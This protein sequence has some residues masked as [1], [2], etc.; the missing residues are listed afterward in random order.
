VP[1]GKD[2]VVI[3]SAVMIVILSCFVAVCAVGTEES[4]AFTVNV[5]VPAAVGVPVMAPVLAF[6]LA[7]DGSVPAE[8]LHVTGGVPPAVC[9][10]APVYAWPTTPLGNAVV[11]TESGVATMVMLSACVADCAGLLE[12]TTFTVKLNTAFAVGVP[13]M[14]PV[15]VLKLAQGGSAPP[16]MLNVNGPSPPLTAIVW[17]YGVPMLPLGNVVVVIEGAGGKLIVM[18]SACVADC[19]GLL[20]STTFTVKLTSP[21]GPVGLPVIRPALFMLNPAGSAPALIE[22]VSVPNPVAPTDWLYAVPS[23]P[24]GSE[25][26]LITGAGGKLIVMLRA[27]VTDCVGLLESTTF[28][29]K[30]AVPF[31]PVGVP[32]MVPDVFMLNPAGSVPALIESVSVP[33]PVACTLWL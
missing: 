31:G 23:T 6:R 17:L 13:V 14:A 10:V 28:T 16:L 25:V 21:L 4:V 3:V 7:H 20:E 5:V 9:S 32:L 29:V 22:S 30:F 27:F 26:V 12:S 19:V 11:L 18:L 33:K 15:L 2:E 24:A 1:F 8:M